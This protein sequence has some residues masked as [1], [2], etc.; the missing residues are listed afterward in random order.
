MAKAKKKQ[1]TDA[2]ELSTTKTL[3]Q[4]KEPVQPASKPITPFPAMDMDISQNT[5]ESQACSVMT[6]S[7]KTISNY[8]ITSNEDFPTSIEALL[9]LEKEFSSL[10]D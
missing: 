3:H 2:S 1:C 4:A 8:I 10:Q 6:P 9:A 5:P 7:T